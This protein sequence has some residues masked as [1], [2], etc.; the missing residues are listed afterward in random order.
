M[1]ISY[2]HEGD[3][4]DKRFTILSPEHATP[5]SV[6]ASP[7]F[8][9]DDGDKKTQSTITKCGRTYRGDNHWNAAKR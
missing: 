6:S 9:K 7:E 4:D 5:L 8:R 2:V 3:H 1:N